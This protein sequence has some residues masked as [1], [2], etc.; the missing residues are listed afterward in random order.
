MSA[1]ATPDRANVLVKLPRR[2]LQLMNDKLP[3]GIT[4]LMVPPD[5]LVSEFIRLP[6]GGED[7]RCPITGMSR[8]WVIERIRES[9]NSDCPILSHH[10]RA[11]GATRGVV[12]IDR[13]SYVAYI[14]SFA[15]PEWAAKKTEEKGSAV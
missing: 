9:Q 12:L 2:T 15:P 13:S 14:E 7:E 5:A 4:V 10:V 11:R 8:T 1:F 3:P 6:E